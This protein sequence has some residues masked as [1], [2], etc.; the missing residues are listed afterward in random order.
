MIYSAAWDGKSVET[1]T[2]RIGGP[3]SRA[4][5]L[6]SAGVLAVSSAGELALSLGCEL[7]WA[8]CRGTLAR[9]PLAGGAPR[10]VLEDVFYADWS[11]DAKNLAAVRAA[12]GRFQ[13]EYPVG[14]VLYQA[15]GWITHPRVSPRG[16]RIAF[17]DHPT[18][19]EDDGSVAIVDLSGHKTVLSSDWKNLKGLAWQPDGD[20]LWFSA[21]RIGRSQAVYAV[22][23]AGKVR[24]V[25]Q[26]PGWI[27]LQEI[28]RDGRL[29]VLQA[30]PRS[31]IMLHSPGH[32]SERVLSWFDWSTVAD[33]APD[34]KKLLFYEWGE[35]ASGN[36]TV[37]LRD[38]SGSD[39]IRLGEGR[40]LALS[41]NGQF[42]L[43]LQAG[44]PP[45]LV[46]LPTGP[47]E[48]KPLPA[49]GALKEV[50]SAT[51]FPDGKRI[52]FVAAGSDGEPH[53]YI[54][55][56][57]GGAPAR[58]VDQ[59]MQAVL[60]SP[61]EKLL[62]GTTSAGDCV[63]RPVDGGNLQSIRGALPG[64]DLVQWSRD[65]QFLYVQRSGDTSVE[66]FRI[67]MASGRREPWRIIGPA[68][69]V[70]MIGI[71]PGAVRM[72]PDGRSIA[73]SY[74]KTLT[75]LYLVNNVK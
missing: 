38:T 67:H 8:E 14:K 39:A 48:E 9:M 66:L 5:G 46:L 57:E 60:V 28:S 45:R 34:G 55:Y 10:E 74:W 33:V 26:A 42:A 7:N 25:L 56:V 36:S 1:F 18:L 59:V 47:G 11:P 40:A 54:Q 72:T 12:N 41:P 63:T 20:E 61:D 6:L 52:L 16:D 27:R 31:R 29:L 73:Y 58:L 51:W 69:P 71:Q 21:D 2:T 23:L 22:T 50:Y 19:G 4:L 49:S 65:R 3:E 62:A 17:L 32:S 75:E 64:D 70:G 30:N 53:S 15:A 37:Y 35:G 13:L 44:P 24:L 68:D 43:A